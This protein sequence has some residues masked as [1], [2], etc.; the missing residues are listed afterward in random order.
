MSGILAPAWHSKE[1]LKNQKA[2]SLLR[3]WP[4]GHQTLVFFKEAISLVF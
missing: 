1:R 4:F 3:S 2:S